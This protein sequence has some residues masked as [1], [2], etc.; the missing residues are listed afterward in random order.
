MKWSC[1]HEE[2]PRTFFD[3]TET[4]HEISAVVVVE[5]G[6]GIASSRAIG[7]CVHV[8]YP[9]ALCFGFLLHLLAWYD[10]SEITH[11]M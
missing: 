9:L 8:I 5:E 3:A 1:A 7:C 11:M 10:H 2:G 6:G 4:S